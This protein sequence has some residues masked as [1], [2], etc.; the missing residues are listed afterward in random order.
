MNDK[1]KLHDELSRH[2]EHEKRD[3]EGRFEKSHHGHHDSH[4]HSGTHASNHNVSE[5]ER[6]ERSKNA[7]REARDSEGRFT[8]SKKTDTKKGGCW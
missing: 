2:A 4:H 1:S 3:A 5:K 7:E 8:D 6:E